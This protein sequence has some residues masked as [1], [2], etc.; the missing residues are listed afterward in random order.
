MKPNKHLKSAFLALLGAGILLNPVTVA[1]AQDDDDEA[2]GPIYELSPFEVDTTSDRGYYAANTISGSRINIAL[3]DMPMPIEVVTSEFIEDTGSTDLRETLRYSAGIILSSQNDSGADLEGVPGG[4]H[5]GSGA[6]A[7]LTDTTIK[8]RGFVTD[9]TLRKGFRRQHG[10]DSVNID[11]VE[12]VRG[13]AALLYGIGNFGGIVNYLPKRPLTF[14]QTV[15][16]A[17]IGSDQR[18]RATFDTTAPATE[19]LSYRVTG[20]IEDN[21]HWTDVQNSHKW[22]ISP[23]L[24]YQPLEK[25]KITLDLELGSQT[26]RGIGFQ[27]MRA[28]PDLDDLGNVINQQGRLQK[29]GFAVFDG[30]NNRTFRLSGPDTFV[31]TDA[32]NVLFELEQNIFEGLDLMIGWNSA[33]ADVEK[34][35]IVNNAY[36]KEFGPEALWGDLTIEPFVDQTGSPVYDSEIGEEDRFLNN[37]VLAYMWEEQTLDQSRDELKAELN[38][39]IKLLQGSRWFNQSHMLLLGV[40]DLKSKKTTK[41]Y[42][43]AGGDQDKFYYKSPND[44]S[45]IRYGSGILDDDS[46]NGVDRFEPLLQTVESE[47]IAENRGYYAVWQG[48]FWNDRITAIYGVR[49]DNN[50]QKI[51][52]YSFTDGMSTG[53]TETVPESQSEV[54]AQSGLSVEVMD[55]V[56]IFALTSEGLEPNF[57]GLRDGYGDAIGATMAESEEVGLK[58]NMLGGKVAATIS[59]YKINVTGA[60]G[61]GLWWAPA[62]AKGRYDPTQA[63]VYQITDFINPD[64]FSTWS[65]A[66]NENEPQVLAAFDAA[67]AAGKAGG[68]VWSEGGQ[69]YVTVLDANGNETPGAAYMDEMYAIKSKYGWVG[70]MFGGSDNPTT[71]ANNAAQDWASAGGNTF[72]ADMVGEEESKGYEFQVL[73]TPTENWQIY[74]S[75]ANTK[76]TVIDQG[77]MPRYPYPQDRWAVWYFPDGNWG[78]QGATVEQAYGDPQDTSTWTGGPATTNGESLD[79]TPEHDF[80]FW[81]SYEFKDGPLN[82][83]KLGLGGDY[84]SEREYLSGFTVAGDAVT[85]SDGK[86]IKLYT[87]EK[88]QLNGMIR[89]DYEWK[90]NPTYIQLNIDNL[91]DDKGLYGYVYEAGISWRLQAGIT[92]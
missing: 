88:F 43:Q 39:Q 72:F 38:Y 75:Y 42:L 1:I 4:V 16:T 90:E 76:R 44:H 7:N 14:Q 12:V 22:F 20:A 59:A 47:A 50:D 57:D 24:V 64:D 48:R 21:E 55:G 60:S 73:Y 65:P 3:Q 26:T 91:T 17:M 51:T 74:A 78:L 49:E 28:R 85:D 2:E 32:N 23:V 71:L 31:T 9:S 63:T 36:L 62:P 67:L 84:Q 45:L 5:N 53:S 54:T 25:T 6:T 86:R 37:A 15:T 34:R 81:T 19:T 89:Y 8:V 35:D 52:D 83:L 40:S 61:L 66:H 58:L 82:G 11:R 27:A 77:K 70:W 13:P 56:T 69:S 30:I 87:S 41:T 29:G 33:E 10:S 92:F 46:M 68:G 79:D 18:Y 80:S